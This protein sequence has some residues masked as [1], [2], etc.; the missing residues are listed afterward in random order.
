MKWPRRELGSTPGSGS[1]PAFGGASVPASR[2]VELGAPVSESA[3]SVD[4]KVLHVPNQ[5]SALRNFAAAR[6]QPR[7]TKLTL[8]PIP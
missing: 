7:P 5:S 4:L 8:Y 6:Q 1:I 3:S 2:Y